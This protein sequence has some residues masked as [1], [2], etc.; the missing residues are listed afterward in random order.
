VWERFVAVRAGAAEN[1]SPPELGLRLALL[2]D[3]IQASA[4]QGGK[5]VKCQ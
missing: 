4:R 2:W 1:P 5:P 3:A